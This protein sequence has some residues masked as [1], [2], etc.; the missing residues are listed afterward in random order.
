M[1]GECEKTGFDVPDD[2]F[3]SRFAPHIHVESL[4]TGASWSE[5]PASFAAGRF[6]L[7]F[8][9]GKDGCRLTRGE[10]PAV[11]TANF[12]AGFRLDRAG[13]IWSS[14]FEG[15]HCLAPDGPPIGRIRIPE[16]ICNLTSSDPRRN[17]LFICGSISPYSV[18]MNGLVLG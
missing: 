13:R 6:A 7:W 12:F 18:M 16:V 11:C 1:Y 10:V 17:R 2:R 8:D 15:V 3:R 9:I 4:W 14:A 5:G